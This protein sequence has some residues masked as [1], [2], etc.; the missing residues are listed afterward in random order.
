MAG[1]DDVV[2]PPFWSPDGRWLGFFAGGRLKKVDP[3]GGPALNICTIQ[4]NL[5][6]TWNRD[7]VIVVAPVNRTVLHRVSAAGG[8]LEPIT[9][10]NAERRENSHRWP[11]FLPDGRHFLFTARSDVKENNMIYVGSLDSREVT[12][13]LVRAVRR[14][15]LGA[16]LHPVRTGG[17][18][19]GARI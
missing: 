7:N 6:A 4:N 15:L 3:S 10:L 12:P 8:M 5:G 2:G 18:G 11:H 13:L 14:R 17:H 9:A 1:T 16:G 19:D